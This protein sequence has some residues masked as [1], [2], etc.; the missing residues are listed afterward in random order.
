MQRGGGKSIHL[1][2]WAG[3]NKKEDSRSPLQFAPGARYQMKVREACMHIGERREKKQ[4]RKKVNEPTSFSCLSTPSSL[5][6]SRQSIVCKQLAVT[7]RQKIFTNP[8]YVE[9]SVASNFNEPT[10][11]MREKRPQTV[12]RSKKTFQTTQSQKLSRA[13]E[14][15]K[16]VVFLWQLNGYVV[17]SRPSL[18][19]AIFV[20][21]Y[22][23]G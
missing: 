6:M 18:F 5:Q 21:I 4:T 7:I 19:L 13:G 8:N 15:K 1:T 2:S 22:S 20:K 23:M 14:E 10:R 3:S 9:F 17:K 12:S 11:V 16:N